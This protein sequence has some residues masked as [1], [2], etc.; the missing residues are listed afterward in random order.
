MNK[1]TGYKLKLSSWFPNRKNGNPHF[2]AFSLLPEIQIHHP[3]KGEGLDFYFTWLF[4]TIEISKE[5][6][7]TK[8]TY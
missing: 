3:G 1:K 5:Y 7:I 8:K 6:V 2:W 4:W